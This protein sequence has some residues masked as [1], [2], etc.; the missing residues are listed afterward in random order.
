M[1]S[2]KK[3]Q[4]TFHV[5]EITPSVIEPSFG[6]GR[7]MYAVFEHNFK[8]RDGDEAR[9]Y[10]SLPAVIAPLKCSL[11]PLPNNPDFTPLVAKLS[12]VTNLL[13]NQSQAC[14]RLPKSSRKSIIPLWEKTICALSVVKCFL[15]PLFSPVISDQNIQPRNTTSSA[16]IVITRPTTVAN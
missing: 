4:K 10:F 3:Y 5:E 14:S 6:V 15:T 1:I 8:I 11:L 12:Q 16:S 9:T 13:L 7:I 2:V